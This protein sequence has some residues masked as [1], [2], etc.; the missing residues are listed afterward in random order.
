MQPKIIRQKKDLATR[1]F[2][3]SLA[4]I[5]QNIRDRSFVKYQKSHLAL[6]GDG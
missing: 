5:D 6:V 1:G 3:Q 2:D 4:D